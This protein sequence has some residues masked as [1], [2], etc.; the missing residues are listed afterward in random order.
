MKPHNDVDL[1]TTPKEISEE[2]DLSMRGRALYRT[3][4]PT[5]NDKKLHKR[6]TL[7]AMD[8]YTYLQANGIT[9]DTLVGLVHAR[10]AT[11]NEIM[12]KLQ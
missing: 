2:F 11:I 6:K 8:I 1:L 5:K 10:K 4:L 7:D 12:G 3:Y 9:K